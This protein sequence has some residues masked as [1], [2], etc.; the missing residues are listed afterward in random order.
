[1]TDLL[2]GSDVRGT[3]VLDVEAVR[4]APVAIDRLT[5]A[6]PTVA[7]T[8]SSIA[9]RLRVTNATAAV[10]TLVTFPV[11]GPFPYGGTT[12]FSLRFAPSEAVRYDG[13]L[14]PPGPPPF[15]RIAFPPQA[16]VVF[17]AVIDLT[18]WLWEGSPVVDL[19][20]SFNVA[21]FE[22]LAGG[23]VAAQLPSRR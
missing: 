17:D 13:Q 16:T 8:S 22:R 9:A 19:L 11:G 6:R 2:F 14:F 12:P 20:W 1:M 18:P 15:M 7:V 23:S 10:V 4:S 21:A 5:I 3:T